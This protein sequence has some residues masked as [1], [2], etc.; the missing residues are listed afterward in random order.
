MEVILF[1]RS[2]LVALID[3]LIGKFGQE[4]M[5]QGTEHLR[6]IVHFSL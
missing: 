6:L 3:Y 5:L 4:K 2:D 1:C